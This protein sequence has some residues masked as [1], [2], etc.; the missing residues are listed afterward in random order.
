VKVTKEQMAVVNVLML[1]DQ[2]RG[3]RANGSSECYQT[4]RGF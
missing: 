4:R 3:L 2:T 1:P